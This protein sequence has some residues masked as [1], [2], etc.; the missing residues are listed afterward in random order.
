MYEYVSILHDN[1]SN[2]FECVFMLAFSFSS[3]NTSTCICIQ[4]L[5]RVFKSI[6]STYGNLNFDGEKKMLDVHS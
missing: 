3:F 2:D 6:N 1:D 5:I 4:F